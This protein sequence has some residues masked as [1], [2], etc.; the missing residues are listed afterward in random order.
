META[1]YRADLA[2]GPE[3]GQAWWA[4]ARDGVR[5]RIGAFNRD[6]AKGTVLLFPGRTEYVEKYGRA[7]HDLAQRGLATL[8]IDWRGQGLSDRLSD[9]PMSG[10]VHHFPDYQQDVAAMVAAADELDLPKPCYLLAHSMGGGIGL[11]SVMEGLD[12]KACAFSA[13]MWGIQLSDVL[14][15]VAWSVSWSSKRLG[16]DHIYA[17]NTT[18]NE[19]YVLIEPFE[20][21]KLTRDADMYQY[22]IDQTLAV[23][24]LGLGGPSL[25]WLHEA[26]QETR[27]LANRPSPAMPCI[28]FAGTEEQIVDLGRIQDRMAKWP[29]SQMHWIEG[30]KHEVLM[31]TPDVRTR[32]F[33]QIAGFFDDPAVAI[34]ESAFSR[35]A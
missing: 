2:D 35:P 31:E 16:M 4:S 19:S 34:P 9:D 33:D 30:G 32:I 10:H 29:G 24:E 5:L 20:S 22:M 1:P 12:V 7:A 8:V 28:T 6:A 25:R 17:P 21:N 14:R 13:P 23:P 18:N 11:R 26:L 15:A 27:T 3:D